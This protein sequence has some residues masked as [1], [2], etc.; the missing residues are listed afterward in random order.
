LCFLDTFWRAPLFQE[1][2]SYFHGKIYKGGTKYPDALMAQE[3]VTFLPLS[4][5]VAA[6]TCMCL[7]LAIIFHCFCMVDIPVSFC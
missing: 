2:E 6:P 3:T 4:Q 5:L 1:V 7:F